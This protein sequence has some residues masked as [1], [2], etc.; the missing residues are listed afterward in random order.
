MIN[1]VESECRLIEAFDRCLAR[2][3]DKSIAMKYL[4][5]HVIADHGEVHF[6]PSEHAGIQHPEDELLGL[7]VWDMAEIDEWRH[8]ETE[9]QLQ[10]G[11]TAKAKDSQ[12]RQQII[13]AHVAETVFRRAVECAPSLMPSRIVVHSKSGEFESCWEQAKVF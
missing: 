7:P 1:F 10:N 9:F 13:S 6:Y 11:T 8:E 12:E 3:K 5:V 4:W 2:R